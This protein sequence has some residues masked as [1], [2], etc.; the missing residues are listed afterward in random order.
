MDPVGLPFSPLRITILIPGVWNGEN[1]VFGGSPDSRL[2]FGTKSD[3]F[4][5]CL[6]WLK[7]WFGVGGVVKITVSVEHGFSRFWAPF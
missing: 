7:P 1:S 3:E 6:G 2:D 4:L 5:R